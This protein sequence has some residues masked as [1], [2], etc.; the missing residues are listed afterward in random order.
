MTKNNILNT[1]KS[2]SN[3]GIKLICIDFDNT[4]L[5]INT[6]GRWDGDSI[7]L[8]NYVRPIFIKFIRNCIKKKIH[9]AIVSF[10]PQ[11]NT[12]RECLEHY[13]KDIIHHIHIKTNNM[14]YK[15]NK[16][17]C[18]LLKTKLVLKRKVPMIL[19]VCNDIYYRTGDIVY[20]KHTLLIDDDWNNIKTAKKSGY[21]TYYFNQDSDVR[22]LADL[23]T[24]EHF[25][26]P[27]S[28]SFIYA[29]V[30]KLILVLSVIIL[31]FWRER[32][33]TDMNTRLVTVKVK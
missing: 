21:K 13:F 28:Y 23:K 2:L 17:F 22:M 25:S 27:T 26:K 15:P 24:I 14:K 31:L 16:T 4:L 29:D 32:T 9:V 19:S 6:Y 5:S 20:P 8:S 3:N 30:C 18:K 12:I 1:L 7:E 33:T 11:E 10:S